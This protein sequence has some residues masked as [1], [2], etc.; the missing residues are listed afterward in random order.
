MEYHRRAL[1]IVCAQC[2]LGLYSQRTYWLEVGSCKLIRL[3]LTSYEVKMATDLICVECYRCCT[4]NAD[5]KK[6]MR[7]GDK[8]VSQLRGLD[9]SRRTAFSTRGISSLVYRNRV[10]TVDRNNR[11]A[12]RSALG[13]VD[14]ITQDIRLL[15]HPHHA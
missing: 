15:F 14:H 13:F 10:D 4:F 5:R 12:I 8:V 3:E 11:H 2:V 9:Y 1:L 6:K 7:K